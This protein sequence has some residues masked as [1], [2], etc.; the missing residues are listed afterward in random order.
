MSSRL[1]EIAS[2]CLGKFGI[3]GLANMHILAPAAGGAGYQYWEQFAHASSPSFHTDI[4]TAL[5]LMTTGRN[6]ALMVTPDAHPQADNIAW[7]KNLTH[8]IGM[9]A[10]ALMNQRSRITQSAGIAELLTVSGYGN[11]IANLYFPYGTAATDIKLLNVTGERNSFIN[12]H[13]LPT[14]ATAL[15]DAGFILADIACNEGYFENCVFGGDTVAWTN[16]ANIRLYGAADRSCRVNFRNCL[17]I[18]NAD[19]AQARFILTVAGMGAGIVTFENCKFL[20]IGTALDYAINGAGLG[21]AD[22][23]FD[24]QCTFVGVTDIVE[25]GKEANVWFGGINVPVGQSASGDLVALFN[26]LACHPDVS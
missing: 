4:E 25:V 24:A 6:D 10:P 16:G 11:L 13:F 5:G 23:F 17:F 22:L 19:N 14:L 20:N 12:C 7:N 18:M 3:P 8:L 15:D 2:S 21:N 26:G 9:C 1:R